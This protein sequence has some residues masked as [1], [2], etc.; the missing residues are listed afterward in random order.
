MFISE[1]LVVGLCV[2]CGANFNASKLKFIRFDISLSF[3]LCSFVRAYKHV[4]VNE[5][6]SKEH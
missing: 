5:V 2:V 6:N 3:F 4:D 1:S